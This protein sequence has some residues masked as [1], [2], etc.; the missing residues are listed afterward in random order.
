MDGFLQEIESQS[1]ILEL[2][3][4][5]GRVYNWV[6]KCLTLMITVEVEDL[7]I[8]QLASEKHEDKETK[9]VSDNSNK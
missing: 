9:N 2:I 1:S 3:K 4:D 6:K 8:G 5:E 7:N